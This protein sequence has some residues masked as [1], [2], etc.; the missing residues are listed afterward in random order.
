[1]N[2]KKK[3][4]ITAIVLVVFCLILGLYNLL[5][6]KTPASDDAA[7]APISFLVAFIRY[8]SFDHFIIFLRAS[9]VATLIRVKVQFHFNTVLQPLVGAVHIPT[10]HPDDDR[11]FHFVFG[12]K[13]GHPLRH[14]L[15]F[16]NKCDRFV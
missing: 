2:K 8:L 5:N 15:F 14:Q 12:L 1:M 16:G 6:D 10:F 4:I 13:I 7:K 9:P 11:V 3:W